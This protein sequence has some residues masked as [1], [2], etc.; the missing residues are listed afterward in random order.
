[1]QTKYLNQLQLIVVKGNELINGSF[2][3]LK[4]SEKNPNI[5]QLRDPKVGTVFLEN[6]TLTLL[7]LDSVIQKVN[8]KLVI[9]FNQ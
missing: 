1:M 2:F 6:L 5:C 7:E 8:H 3:T 4:I 9:R